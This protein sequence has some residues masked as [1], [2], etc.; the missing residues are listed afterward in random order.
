M[1]EYCN[2]G[3]TLDDMLRDQLVWGV[4]NDAIQQKLLGEAKLTF[5]SAM[6]LAQGLETV[7]QNVKTLKAS[8]QGYDP[9][10]SEVHKV[11]NTGKGLICHCCGRIGHIATKCHFK[12]AVCHK[13]GKKGHLKVVCRSK[14]KESG[15]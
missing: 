4:K 13:Y 3:G 1:A 6:E 9:E 11:T 14:P 12:D 15:Q 8:T 10:K 5:K 2:F 7:A